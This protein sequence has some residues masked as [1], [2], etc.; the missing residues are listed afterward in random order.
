M[1]AR[2]EYIIPQCFFRWVSEKQ[3]LCNL[4]GQ[5]GCFLATAWMDMVA[6]L[7]KT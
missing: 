6:L 5:F 3:I 2:T 4:K 7:G 1:R